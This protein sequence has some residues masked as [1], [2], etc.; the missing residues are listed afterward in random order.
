MMIESSTG[1][2]HDER[3]RAKGNVGV[4]LVSVI[5]IFLILII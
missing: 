4:H 3:D 2:Y 1:V 5:A